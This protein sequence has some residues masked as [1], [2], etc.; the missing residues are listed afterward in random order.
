MFQIRHEF[1]DFSPFF[2][3]FSLNLRK[4]FC[5]TKCYYYTIYFIHKYKNSHTYEEQSYI[6]I[7]IHLHIQNVYYT[8]T[9]KN[10]L[11][12]IH[13]FRYSESHASSSSIFS[14]EMIKVTRVWKSICMYIYICI[15]AQP[16]F[17]NR[18]HI[19]VLSP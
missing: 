15:Y 4:P 14:W 17:G 8:R 9:H 6:S 16:S 19:H 1:V 11:K 13:N 12:I 7:S 5:E 18:N 10:M 3:V 2:I